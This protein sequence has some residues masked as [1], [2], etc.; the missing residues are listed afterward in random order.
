VPRVAQTGWGD[1]LT[2]PENE[3]LRVAASRVV[4]IEFLE[5]ACL[6]FKRRF[7]LLTNI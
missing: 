7:E 5:W 3:G 4:Q 6:Y 1:E 2:V